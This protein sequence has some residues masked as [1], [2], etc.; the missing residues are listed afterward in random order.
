MTDT[1]VNTPVSLFLLSRSCVLVAAMLAW[2]LLLLFF[3]AVSKTG[4]LLGLLRDY[5]P[6][7]LDRTHEVYSTGEGLSIAYLSVQ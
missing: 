6:V 2:S 1:R 4:A 5:V 3:N 7:V